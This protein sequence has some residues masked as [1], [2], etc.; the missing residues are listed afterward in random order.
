[1]KQSIKK[2]FIIFTYC[3][4]T[5]ILS[6]TEIIVDGVR[7][8]VIKKTQSATLKD[9]SNCSGEF[10]VPDYVTYDGENYPVSSIG[11]SA[12]YSCHS[13]TSISIPN[14]VTK[15]GYSAF[16]DCSYLSSINIPN[17]VTEIASETFCKCHWLTSITIPNSVKKIGSQAF[18]KCIRLSSIELSNSV[19]EIE[20]LAFAYCSSLSSVVMSNSLSII[21]SG[22]FYECSSLAAID[23]PN[24]VT[25]IG[26]YA[27]SGCA[28]IKSVNISDI[29]AW[30]NIRFEDNP[31]S[32]AHNLY[33]NEEPVENLVIPNS[34]TEIYKNAFNGCT[35]LKS[36]LIP[37]SVIKIGAS[38]FYG[39][40]SLETISIPNTIKSIEYYTFRDCTA[41]IS[42]SIPNSVTNI[43][44]N[45]FEGCTSLVSIDIP[46]SVTN[47]EDAFSGCKS[48][49][50]IIIP[51]SIT[52]IK[53][54]TFSGCSSLS[55]ISIPSSIKTIEGR[56]FANCSD[57]A[58]VY[59][60]AERVPSTNNEAFKDSYIEYA[61][62]YIPASAINDY[63]STEPWSAFGK[64][65]TLEGIEVPDEPQITQCETPVISYQDGEISF[66]SSTEGAAY[67]YTIKDADV[68]S[69]K[70]TSG[71][72]P[73]FASLDV[74]VY[75]IAEGYLQSETATATL[76]WLNGTLDNSSSVQML[77]AN[78]RPIL[79]SV[80]GGTIKIKGLEEKECVAFYSSNGNYLGQA[81]SEDGEVT[82]SAISSGIVIAKI[83]DQN[84]KILMK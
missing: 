79:V 6:A 73:L 75:A 42:I 19:I 68:V 66:S 32:Y 26:S 25:Q 45:A 4:V 17:S 18:E 51:N 31:L 56:V 77:H 22:A 58:D 54:G 16:Y 5:G 12:F 62:L 9:G 13:L 72:V 41:L 43:G 3:I 78:K 83:N 82:F 30:C 64:I 27:F 55:T 59:C 61:K 10:I 81:D 47:I 20:D 34:V 35:T 60:Y 71:I 49:K 65:V 52:N 7:Y 1:M 28:A 80:A 70:Y 29:E 33:L 11:E 2:L 24:S 53:Y 69:E 39:C 50:S 46:N 40:S 23:I 38:A 8:E 14:S 76:H 37:N 67:Y 63:K 48:L 44:R 36:V 21:G 74:S 15:I 57:L 84:I